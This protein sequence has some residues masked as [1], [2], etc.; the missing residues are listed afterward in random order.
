[1]IYKNMKFKNFIGIDVSK[2]TLDLCV[3]VNNQKIMVCKI[4]NNP[5]GLT[6]FWKELM[7]N[8][9]DFKV[10]ES[11]FCMEHT[12]IYNQHLLTFLQQK[13]AN[14]CLENPVQIKFSNGMQRGKSDQ[15]DCERIA[16]YASKENENLKL[17]EPPRDVVKML[18]NLTVLRTRLIMAKKTLTVPANEIKLFDKETSKTISSCCE[19]SIKRLDLDLQKVE[20]KINEIIKNDATLKRLFAI[21]TSINGVGPIT[22]VELIICTNEFKTITKAKKFAC[23]AGIV[24]FE[25]VSGTSIKSRAKV[26]HRANKRMKMLLHMGALT[27]INCNQDLKNYYARKVEEGKN[28]MLVLNSI[29]NKIVQRVFACVRDNKLYEKNYKIN[30][31]ES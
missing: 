11:V 3:M 6:S 18:K 16:M 20:S 9:I 5:K 29:R 2:L 17:W 30:L 27:A 8:C 14:I 31:F 7:K 26:S 28:K 13:N 22:A 4:E 19:A 25:Y 1:M 15:I 21:T 23:Y 24:P 12:G 10:S